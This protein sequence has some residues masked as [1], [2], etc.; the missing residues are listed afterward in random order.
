MEYPKAVVGRQ[1]EIQQLERL[2]E[3]KKSEFLAVYG[4]RRVGKTFLIREYF[5][6]TFDFQVSGLTNASTEQQLFN[7]DAAISRQS[8][9]ALEQASKNWLVAFQRL[10][11]HLEQ[12]T[13]SGK[14]TLFFDELSWFDT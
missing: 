13:T 11:D 10:I 14:I 2:V 9:V 12:K 8:A 1:K 5:N 3:S 7:F 4:R 6:Y